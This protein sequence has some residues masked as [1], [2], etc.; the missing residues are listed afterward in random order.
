MNA[1][2]KLL[3]T[4]AGKLGMSPDKLMNALEK[5]DMNDIV[6]NMNPNDKQKIKSILEDGS[7]VEKLMQ[8]PQAAAMMKNMG[9]P[10]TVPQMKK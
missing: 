5:G 10:R 2:E 9:V 7:A 3:Q 8:S 6:A 4:A 1:M